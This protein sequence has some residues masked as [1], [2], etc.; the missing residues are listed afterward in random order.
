MRYSLFA[1]IAAV[2]LGLGCDQIDAPNVDIPK[3]ETPPDNSGVNARDAEPS[4]KTPIDQNENSADV[5]RTAAI[6]RKVLEIPEASINARN[7]KIITQ[8][9]KVTL[10]G[11]VDSEAEKEAIYRAAVDVA[12]AENVMNELE[13]TKSDSG[14]P[15]P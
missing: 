8:N 2:G 6:R 4:A 15:N 1:L 14:Q 11:P 7:A 5:E 9:W 12:G 10:R 3:D 13:V